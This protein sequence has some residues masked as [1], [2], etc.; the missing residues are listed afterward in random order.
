VLTECA[1]LFTSEYGIWSQSAPEKMRGRHIRLSV[2]RL[3]SEFLPNPQSYGAT[4]RDNTGSIA[5]QAFST[6]V[7]LPD[8]RQVAFCTQ[9]VVREEF[10]RRG[11]ATNLLHYLWDRIDCFGW[12]I[13]T[14]N[15]LSIRVLEK[16]TE[17]QCR[18]DVMKPFLDAEFDAI[19]KQITYLKDASLRIGSERCTV[20][21]NF[22]LDHSEIPSLLS[23]ATNG[24]RTLLLYPIVLAVIEPYPTPPLQ[25]RGC[26]ATCAREK[27]FLESLSSH[28]RCRLRHHR[29]QPVSSCCRTRP[30]K[31]HFVAA[32]ICKTSAKYLVTFMAST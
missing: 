22:Q 13:C 8:G 25:V 29:R 9:L 28:N 20:N 2:P 5:A 23:A 21:S 3:K 19:T 32:S 24:S 26:W 18:P 17:R 31:L 7:I 27:S 10:R 14:A 1:A 16:V 11:L 15:P 12:A 30:R 6:I 4:A